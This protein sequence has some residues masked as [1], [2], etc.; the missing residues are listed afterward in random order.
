MFFMNFIGKSPALIQ[1]TEAGDH[2]RPHPYEHAGKPDRR[3]GGGG[4]RFA[5]GFLQLTAA[6]QDGAALGI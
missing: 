4:A 1:V 5:G 3:P 6:P 2:L